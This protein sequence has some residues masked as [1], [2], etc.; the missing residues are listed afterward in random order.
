MLAFL[1]SPIQL[2]VLLVVVLVIF[3]PE[4]MKDIGKQLGRAM[5]EIRRTGADFTNAMNVDDT[6][7]HS[8]Y[9]PP[10]YDNYSSSSYDSSSNDSWQ[11]IE[12]AAAPEP[13]VGDFAASAMADTSQDYGVGVEAP[14][15]AAAAPADPVYGVLAPPDQSV[16]RSGESTGS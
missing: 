8:D 11:S 3:G 16:P 6:Q 14:P 7:H 10:R 5:R 4:K 2:A 13:P 12:S 9:E 15:A 1:D